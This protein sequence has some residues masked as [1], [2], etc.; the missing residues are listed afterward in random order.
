[1]NLFVAGLVIGCCLIGTALYAGLETGIISMHR[2]RLK[3]LVRERV[4]GADIIQSFLH[5]PDHLLGTTLVGTNL[6]MV[7]ASVAAASICS[8]LL[9]NAGSWVSG[10]VMTV[11]ILLGCEYVPKAWFQGMPAVRV[12]P[13]AGFLKIS[14]WVLWPISRSV[15]F[16]TRLLFPAP[17]RSHVLS[18]TFITRDELLHLTRETTQT[19][20]L[21][22]SERRM[23]QSVF[24]LSRTT[25]GGL[26]VPLSPEMFL[27]PGDDWEAILR[28]ARDRKSMHVPVRDPASGTC[29]GVVFVSD[30]LREQRPAKKTA[31]D[32]LR[33]L[34]SVDHDTPVD[35]L[36]PR[37][38]LAEQ[39]ALL[40]QHAQDGVV[41]LITA[42]D[43]IELVV[44]SV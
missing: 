3:H 35:E 4:K 36:I 43:V 1:M 26:M 16:I 20:E 5:R 33:S 13:Y 12:L 22:R 28:S 31:A 23:I 38:R 42:E 24:T 10:V 2:L 9:P 15:M 25:A 19:S 21:T 30:V 34:P 14:G 6:C 37:M 39:P 17:H 29:L 40:V 32:Y 7:G 8:R 11:V 41:G 18:A 44:G 27:R